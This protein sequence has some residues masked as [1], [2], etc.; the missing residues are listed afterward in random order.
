MKVK[1]K[2]KQTIPQTWK[3]RLNKF[4]DWLATGWEHGDGHRGMLP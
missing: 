2:K 3:K 4:L 1:Q